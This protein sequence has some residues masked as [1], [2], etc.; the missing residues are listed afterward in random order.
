M[1]VGTVWAVAGVEVA[2]AAGSD[3]AVITAVEC[4]P[5]GVSSA[6][7]VVGPVEVAGADGAAKVLVAAEVDWRSEWRADWLCW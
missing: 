3:V 2:G 7:G 6:D 5:V 4:G 1:Q